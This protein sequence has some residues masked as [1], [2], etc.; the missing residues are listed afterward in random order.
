MAR[1]HCPK[2]DPNNPKKKCDYQTNFK[3]EMMEHASTEHGAI[4]SEHTIHEVK[5]KR[6]NKISSN[7]R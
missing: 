6:R 3:F 1:F 2:T 7:A 5:Y 4:F